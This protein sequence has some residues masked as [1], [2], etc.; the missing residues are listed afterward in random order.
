MTSNAIIMCSTWR[1]FSHRGL[2]VKVINLYKNGENVSPQ[3]WV[4][5]LGKMNAWQYFRMFLKNI[6]MSYWSFACNSV[7]LF[8]G[9]IYTRDQCGFSYS[10]MYVA[11]T[12]TEQIKFNRNISIKFVP[13]VLNQRTI[14]NRTSHALADLIWCLQTA[15][16][17][18]L[19]N[20]ETAFNLPCHKY[21]RA[22]PASQLSH[23]A[24]WLFSL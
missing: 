21:S 1:R 24:A 18:R 23:T 8:S 6:V 10:F 3:Q 20:T 16:N 14:D 9:I 11:C 4:A 2:S 17:V 22:G 7:P 13:R 5:V 12:I 15:R 19:S